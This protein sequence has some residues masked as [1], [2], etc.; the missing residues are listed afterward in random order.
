MHMCVWV[1][2]CTQTASRLSYGLLQPNVWQ[3]TLP[4]GYHFAL[5]TGLS[6]GISMGAS[7]IGFPGDKIIA[8]YLKLLRCCVI[9]IFDT[10]T[11]PSKIKTCA[12]G[13]FFYQS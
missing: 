3:C 7:D 6:E 9:C 1:C 13:A 11:M 5:Q 10:Q 12:P 8:F 2:T 4:V